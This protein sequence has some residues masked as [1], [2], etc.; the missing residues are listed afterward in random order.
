MSNQSLSIRIRRVMF[1]HHPSAYLLAA[2]AVSL[3][4]FAVFDGRTSAH[5]FIAAFEVV[6]LLVVTWII[7][8]N[9]KTQWLTWI[10]A[11]PAFILSILSGTGLVSGYKEWAALMVGILNFFAAGN[12]IV[13]MLGDNRITTD[14]LFAAGST[15]TLF[16]WGFAYI[17]Q[18]CQYTIAG[19]LMSGINSADYRT[20]T[21]LLLF[22]FTNLSATGLSDV[23]PAS[24]YVRIL[25]V[26]EQFT[27]IAYV[28]TVVA[29]L[30]SLA[31]ETRDQRRKKTH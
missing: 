2:Q 11:I 25:V 21:E 1:H 5:E 20:F 12:M 14:E 16:G 17:Y 6:V 15:F 13:Y 29:R 8:E 18:F 19:S 10:I 27:G 4:L 24:A 30:V 26:L 22:S 3:V 9:T 28:T 31:M 23:F 7:T